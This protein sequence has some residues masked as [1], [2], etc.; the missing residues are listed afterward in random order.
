[1]AYGF[2]IPGQQYCIRAEEVPLPLNST[3]KPLYL[4]NFPSSWIKLLFRDIGLGEPL[5]T[6]Q[7]VAEHQKTI[8][9][10]TVKLSN[11]IKKIIRNLPPP[12]DG[13]NLLLKG[14]RAYHI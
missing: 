7:Q 11:E 8:D 13:E 1:M 2:A 14:G 4:K 6:E 10:L 9:E 3:D 12:L 5:I